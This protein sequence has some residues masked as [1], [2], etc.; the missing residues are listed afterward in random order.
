VKILLLHALPLDHRMWEPQLRALASHEVHAPD[1]YMLGSSMDEWADAVLEDVD[2]D[3]VAVGASMGGYCACAIA[4]RRAERLRGI[5]LAGSRAD[6]DPP[7]R[8]PMRD[9]WVRIVRDEGAEG[10]WREMGP[11]LFSD[12]ADADLVERARR[13]ALEQ[14]PE[15]LVHAVEAIRDR[16]DSTPAVTSGMPLLV[17]AGG[18]DRLIPAEVGQELAAASATGRALVLDDVGHLPN[19]ERPEEFNRVLLDFLDA[20]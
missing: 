16:P 1:L 10:L 19:L 15:G 17:V 7:D 5:V 12:G 9:E 4:R 18:A 3:L 20:L 8:R 6:A 14:E 2:G 13:I 11:K